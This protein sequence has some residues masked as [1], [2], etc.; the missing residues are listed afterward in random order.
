MQKRFDD[1][2]NP[3]LSEITEAASYG[4]ALAV[5]GGS[6]SIALLHLATEWAK[7]RKIRLVIFSV[8]HNLRPESSKEIEFVRMVVAQFSHEFYE[9]SWD[10]GGNKVAI[11][12]RAR[13]ARYNMMSEKCR[14]LGI[15]T[16]L[17][18]HHL[19]DRLETYLMHKNKKNGIL[20]TH[21]DK[22]KV[23][24]VEASTGSLG[25]GIGFAL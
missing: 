22:N 5:S 25:N 21:P 20:A 13:A 8:N 12:A 23:P 2:I 19:D 16:M 4:V 15:N 3:L 24:G 7:S 10:S 17:T 9:L 6:D 1:N 18:A 11:Q 14:E